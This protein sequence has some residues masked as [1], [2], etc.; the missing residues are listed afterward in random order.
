MKEGAFF[1]NTARGPIVDEAALAESLRSGHLSG[2]ALDVLEEEPMNASCVLKE[3]PNCT[4]TPHVAWAPIETRQRL[5]DVVLE[6]VQAFLEG[7]P[8]NVVEAD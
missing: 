6:N 4:I 2:A 3:I 7:S 8:L 5:V 1:I